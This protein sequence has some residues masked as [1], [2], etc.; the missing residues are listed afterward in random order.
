MNNRLVT[1]S[2]RY[3]G[4]DLRIYTRTGDDGTTG[5][6]Y[7]KRV[8]KDSLP[9]ELNGSV[10]ET[11]A[12]IGLARANS[13]NEELNEIL[14]AL[15]RELWILMAEVATA[16][17]DRRKLK[18]GR[19]LV[20]QAMVVANEERID[21]IAS[22]FPPI[23]DFVLPGQNVVSAH[24]DMA[25]SVCRRAE[26]LSVEFK[27]RFPDSLVQIY[28]NRLSDLLWTLA[29]WQEGESLRAKDV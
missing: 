2:I 9:I 12:A 1:Q 24:L 6:L 27:R 14:L 25:R 7:G 19:T 16:D 28:L 3:R 10:D 23:V 26:R 11:Q 8:P 18:P 15:E 29:R 13:E 4:R 17:T 22:R 5:L 21:Q 20:D